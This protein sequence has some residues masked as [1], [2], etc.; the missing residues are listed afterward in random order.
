MFPVLQK[1]TLIEDRVQRD[2]S[3]QKRNCYTWEQLQV[4]WNID[5]LPL[6]ANTWKIRRESKNYH[7]PPLRP[8]SKKLR[9]VSRVEGWGLWQF[10]WGEVTTTCVNQ[11]QLFE[12]AQVLEVEKSQVQTQLQHKAP[13]GGDLN[14]SM[15]SWTLLSRQSGTSYNSW[16]EKTRY[17]LERFTL[18]MCIKWMGKKGVQV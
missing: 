13:G 2:S 12:L 16:A 1:G 14:V 10:R 18:E 3:Q 6:G 15:K 17:A 11:Q 7:R 4:K 5:N 9:A 8:S